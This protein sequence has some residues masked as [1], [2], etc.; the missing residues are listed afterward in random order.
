M[1]GKEELSHYSKEPLESNPEQQQ[2]E[3][4]NGISSVVLGKIEKHYFHPK[5]RVN[6]FSQVRDYTDYLIAYTASMYD[7]YFVSRAR[8]ALTS[9]RN[10]RKHDDYNRKSVIVEYFAK[11]LE[12]AH[13]REGIPPIASSIQVTEVF[14][15]IRDRL[16]PP[17]QK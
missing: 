14:K 4:K 8:T 12:H 7:S 11:S 1:P 15:G 9:V 13:K 17:T 16:K 2:V 10:S 6:E 5:P 3:A